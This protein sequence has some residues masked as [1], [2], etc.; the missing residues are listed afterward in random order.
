MNKVSS[1]TGFSLSLFVMQS[2]KQYDRFK[3]PRANLELRRFCCARL[4]AGTFDSSTC[5]PEGERYKIRPRTATQTLKP[6]LLQA[7]NLAAEKMAAMFLAHENFGPNG[8][9]H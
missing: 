9:A 4:Q 2:N 3:S 7:M 5:S 6:L 1:R 8:G